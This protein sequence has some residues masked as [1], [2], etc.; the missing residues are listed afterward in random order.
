MSPDQWAGLVLIVGALAWIAVGIIHELK[1]PAPDVEPGKDA[2][3]AGTN[4][5]PP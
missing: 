1:T 2:P 4:Q 3:G 5:S